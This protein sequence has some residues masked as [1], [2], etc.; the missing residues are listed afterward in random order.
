[1]NMMSSELKIMFSVKFFEKESVLDYLLIIAKVL[2]ATFELSNTNIKLEILNDGHSESAVKFI[3]F[4]NVK[5]NLLF[6][7]NRS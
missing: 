5:D 1:M 2:E 7:T 6:I 4:S 3:V